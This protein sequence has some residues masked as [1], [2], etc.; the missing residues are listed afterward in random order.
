M[1]LEEFNY[2]L[3]SGRIA[4]HPLP[5]RDQSRLIVYRAGQISHHN[6]TEIS[7][8]LPEKSLLF[9]ND[10]KVIPARI[11][12]SRPTGGKIEIFLLN[13]VSPSTVI[14]KVMETKNECAW[15][16]LIGNKKKW[17]SE[18]LFLQVELG[19]KE[20][21]LRLE[22]INYADNHV[23]FSWDDSLYSFAEI[24]E[25]TGQVPLPPYLNR[26]PVNEDKHWYQTV[27]SKA[28]GAVAAPTAGLHITENII[29]ELKSANHAID[30]LTLHVGAGTFQPVKS[31]FVTDHK[32]HQEQIV[33]SKQNIEAIVNQKNHIIPVGTTSMR[34]LESMYWH[35]VQLLNDKSSAFKISKELP[36]KTGFENLPSIDKALEAILNRMNQDGVDT[37]IGDTGIYIYPGYKFQLCH[38]LITNFHQPK[39]SLILLIAAFIGNDWRRIYEDAL[40]SDYRFLSYGD[41]S[42]LLPDD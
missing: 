41:S 23:R 25:A 31:E 20:V 33:I 14:S 8:L 12:A 7:E 36:Y 39:S 28:E 30:H 11:V 3:P 5:Q 26:K 17:R 18:I 6:F 19:S 27:Y 29:K 32:M 37:I 13:P 24:V 35:G 1:K 9:F 2:D 16:C 10:T 22:L 21:N 42:L 15:H 4:L 40:A 34:S 38:G